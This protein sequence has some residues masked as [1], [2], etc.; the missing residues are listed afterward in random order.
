MVV[1][2]SIC[3]PAEMAVFR[4]LTNGYNRAR[5]ETTS[6]G[7]LWGRLLRVPTWPHRLSGRTLKMSA[8]LGVVDLIGK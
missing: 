7:S 1:R 2:S 8:S 3:Y 4:K 6:G 5:S